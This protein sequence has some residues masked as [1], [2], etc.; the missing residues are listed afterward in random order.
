M[1]AEKLV[2][3]KRTLEGSASS[4]RL[5]AKGSLPGVVYGGKNESER[6]ELE[7]HAVEQVLHHHSSESILLDIDLEGEGLT[8]VLLKEVQHHPVTGALVHVDLQRVSAN[9]PIQVEVS[10]ELKGEPEGVKAGGLLD[11]VQHS[12]LIE[13]LPGDMVECIEVDVSSLEIG[14]AVYISD[15]QVDKK[16]TILSDASQIIAAVAAPK[17]AEEEVETEAVA[18]EPEVITEKTEEE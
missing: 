8:S 12:V 3:K 1:E 13:A 2:V 18:G 9:K 7:M 5:R 4:R 11:H 14:Q 16:L 15:L 17:V 6:I 10:L